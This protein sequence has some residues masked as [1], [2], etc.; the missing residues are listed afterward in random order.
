MESHSYSL[1]RPE[2][3]FDM[4]CEEG[5]NGFLNLLDS[6]LFSGFEYIDMLPGGFVLLKKGT[7]TPTGQGLEK[8][9]QQQP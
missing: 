1:K 8:R 3:Y 7:S 5:R 9:D 4:G 2:T 6:L